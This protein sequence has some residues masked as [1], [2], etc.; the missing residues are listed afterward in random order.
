M[1]HLILIRHSITKQQ[2][3]VSSHEWTLTDEGCARCKILA[4]QLRPYHV[5]RMFSSPET[6]ARLTATLTAA[7]LHL[8]APEVLDGVEETHRATAPFTATI[9][10]FQAAIRAAMQQ[11]E[12]LLFGEETFGAAL[13]RFTRAINGLLEAYPG[14]TLAVVTHGTILALYLAQVSGQD[15][16]ELWQGLEMPAY[17]VLSLP[18]IKL[19]QFVPRLFD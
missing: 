14:Q 5:E 2:L 6:R 3:T 19:A 4:E 12:A 13:R 1:H 9:E 8:P 11:P 15:T 10:A 17:V 16:F 18:E 7:E